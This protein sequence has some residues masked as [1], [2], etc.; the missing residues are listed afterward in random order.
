MT[1]MEQTAHEKSIGAVA[2]INSFNL[3][4]E[5]WISTRGSQG[6]VEDVG[7]IELFERADDIACIVGEIPTQEAAILRLALAILYR[8]V[9]L[10]EQPIDT[11][12]NWWEEKRL[13][14]DE[15]RAYLE[16]Y[17][18]R[19]DLLHP[20]TPFFQVATLHTASGKT[21]GLGKVIA[22]L[23]DG[24]PF[25]TTRAPAEVTRLSYA[26]A[27]RWLVHVHAYDYSG[28]KSGA[29]GDDRV[30]GGKGYPIG[31]GFAGTL[32]LLIAE[33]RNLRETLL[34][35]LVLRLWREDDR[36]PWEGAPL[37]PSIDP[38]RAHPR[39][40]ADCATWQARRV[41]L[42]HD[43][44]GV[45]DVVLAN[46]EPLGPQN[47]Q[48]V[49]PS[50]SWRFSEPQ[51]KK[52][53]HTVYMPLEHQPARSMWRGLA[54]TLGERGTPAATKA[55][56]AA[57]QTAGLLEW[58]GSLREEHVLTPDQ[59][60]VFRAVGIAY[61]AQ[62]SSV[63][64]VIDDRLAL[65]LT[66][67]ADAATRESATRAVTRSEEAV[68]ALGRLASNLADAA[69]RHLLLGM[70]D[71]A[72]SRAVEAAYDALDIPFRRWLTSL[73]TVT[74]LV[75]A[76][77]SWEVD[78]RRIITRAA[79]DLV[80]SAGPPALAGRAVNGR[81]LNTAIAENYFRVALRQALPYA[82]PPERPTS[83]EEA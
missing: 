8:A 53:K 7:L 35:N 31:T 82:Y 34:L 74:D 65:P 68:R 80:Q 66:V 20:Q 55:N 23:P 67:I 36:V 38:T 71:G 57:Y 51:T 9:D 62:S 42:L 64:A 54:S 60:V 22:E 26:E 58:L 11:W 21:S 49:E 32:G 10:D 25:F 46:G 47:R 75:D 40:P 39:G 61:G 79:A 6:Q 81:Y 18:D 72:R 16:Q 69:G 33:G 30:K 14:V 4:S 43:G 76:A 2:P 59:P 3:L 27:A 45:H 37:G 70:E 28:I 50:S 19:F 24:A 13:P 29:V 77:R 17:R 63:E 56:V 48:A 78:V 15:V 41:L 83:K 5:P 52:L 73:G 1:I 12:A 44:S